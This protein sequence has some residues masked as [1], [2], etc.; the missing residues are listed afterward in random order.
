MRRLAILFALLAMMSAVE[1]IML[2]EAFSR[3]WSNVWRAPS[4]IARTLMSLSDWR[5]F[6]IGRVRLFQR[7]A[8]RNAGKWLG[9]SN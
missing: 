1:H 8:P 7:A 2:S 9:E 3:G 6:L 4:R 5:A